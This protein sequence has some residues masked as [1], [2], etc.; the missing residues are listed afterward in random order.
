MKLPAV[1]S[2]GLL[3]ALPPEDRK[4]LGR[5]GMT[6]AEAEKKYLAG[7]EE[8]LQRDIYKWLFYHEIYFE[9]DRMDKR[10]SGKRGRADFRICVPVWLEPIKERVGLWLS[11]E[12]KTGAETLRPA[13]AAEAAR[14][15]KSAG[16]FIVAYC[17]AD[18]IKAVRALQELC[19]K[20]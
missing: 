8:E 13:Q 17:L 7:Q 12:A 1:P 14:L 5:A 10:T 16:R 9:W 18:V 11:V 19:P 2:E 3:R 20:A 4:R 15:R 6:R